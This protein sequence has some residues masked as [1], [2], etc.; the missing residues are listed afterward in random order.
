MKNKFGVWSLI[1]SFVPWLTVW[2]LVAINFGIFRLF[3]GGLLFLGTYIL[4]LTLSIFFSNLFA[5]LSLKSKTE[6]KTYPMLAIIITLPAY[7]VLLYAL[8]FIFSSL[9]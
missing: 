5:I 3:S 8:F 9:I 4:I 7:I 6:F 1:L 2:A